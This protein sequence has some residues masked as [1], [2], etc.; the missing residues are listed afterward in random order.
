VQ[1]LHPGPVWT[2][3]FLHDHG[4]NGTPW[5]VLTVM[6][7]FTREGLALKGA[8]SLPAP[9]VLTVLEG[10]VVIHGRSPF[11]RSDNGPEFIALPRRAGAA[12][13]ANLVHRP[14]LPLAAR[15]WRKR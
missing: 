15:V 10:V 3:D 5:K 4:L 14:R 13:N 1:A 11:I 12:P 7:E 6:A 9:R 2:S 8:L